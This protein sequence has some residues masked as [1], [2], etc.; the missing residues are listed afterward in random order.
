M[1][2]QGTSVQPTDV[3]VTVQVGKMESQLQRTPEV[4][5][6]CTSVCIDNI[7]IIT[8]VYQ[9]VLIMCLSVFELNLR[10]LSRTHQ[11]VHKFHAYCVCTIRVDFGVLHTRTCV[12]AIVTITNTNVCMYISISGIWQLIMARQRLSY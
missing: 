8:Y 9:Y 3:V 11:G 7:C 10:Y 12:K 2:T 6:V 4:C 1:V 5:Q